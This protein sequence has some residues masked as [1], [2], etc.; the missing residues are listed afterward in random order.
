MDSC[1]I[2]VIGPVMGLRRMYDPTVL[3]EGIQVSDPPPGWKKMEQIV[4]NDDG[5]ETGRI[6]YKCNGDN[7]R[8]G[9]Q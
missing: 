4:K 6:P 7:P 2:I 9:G 1:A 3:R 8:W 5:K